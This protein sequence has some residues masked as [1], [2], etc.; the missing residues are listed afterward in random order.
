[1]SEKTQNTLIERYGAISIYDALQRIPKLSD[2]Q[3]DY[4][5]KRGTDKRRKQILD[6]LGDRRPTL[7]M[8]EWLEQYCDSLIN[9]AKQLHST[10][11]CL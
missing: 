10:G 7:L 5:F 9:Q 11:T 6:R 8:V 1:M 3:L 4:W 2:K